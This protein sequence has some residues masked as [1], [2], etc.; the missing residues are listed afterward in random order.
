MGTS[1]KKARVIIGDTWSDGYSQSIPNIAIVDVLH[2][3]TANPVTQSVNFTSTKGRFWIDLDNEGYVGSFDH[4][5]NPKF[6]LSKASDTTNG[7]LFKAEIQ[8]FYSYTNGSSWVHSASST[9]YSSFN[10]GQSWFSQPVNLF[11]NNINQDI[12]LRLDVTYYFTKSTI[13]TTPSLSGYDFIT[14]PTSGAG[15]LLIPNSTMSALD[16][17]T[18]TT[19]EVAPIVKSYYIK[20]LKRVPSLNNFYITPTQGE[21]TLSVNFVPNEPNLNF[22][23]FPNDSTHNSV[24]WYYKKGDDSW[25]LFSNS[26]ENF[27]Y[28]FSS[29]GTYYIKLEANNSDDPDPRIS[30][31][32]P[33][34]IRIIRGERYQGRIAMSVVYAPFSKNGT[35]SIEQYFEDYNDVHKEFDETRVL[36][37]GELPILGD[38]KLDKFYFASIIDQNTNFNNN[39]INVKRKDKPTI[40]FDFDTTKES[41]AKYNYPLLYVPNNEYSLNRVIVGSGNKTGLTLEQK[42][43]FCPRNISIIA[44]ED[45]G[46]IVDAETGEER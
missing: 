26:N 23:N 18:Y 24:S 32:Y 1:L 5:K 7:R 42:E 12:V 41:S 17:T 25:T 11:D 4:S 6:D 45:Y 15:N 28:D 19:N 16:G 40:V 20:I 31:E 38:S 21:P 33:D 29:E 10:T 8:Q 14:P 27:S 9:H 34:P 36:E 30:Y 22:I 13:P 2:T 44:V 35:S 3:A 46:P 39:I 43:Y 37:S